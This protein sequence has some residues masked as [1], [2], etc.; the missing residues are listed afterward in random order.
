MDVSEILDFFEEAIYTKLDLGDLALTEIPHKTFEFT[1]LTNLNLSQ[2]SLT[3]IPVEIVHLTKLTN[4]NLSHN[5]LTSLPWEMSKMA[6]LT[7]LDVKRNNLSDLPREF[8]NLM[9]LE[10]LNL[11]GNK[12]TSIPGCIAHLSKLVRLD[13]A[14]NEIADI[15]V[16]LPSRIISLDLGA[17]KLRSF[18]VPKNVLILDLSSN[19]LETIDTNGNESLGILKIDDN[20][21]KSLPE[22]GFVETVTLTG[23]VDLLY[24]NAYCGPGETMS[25][26]KQC[27]LCIVQS[28][29]CELQFYLE[30]EALPY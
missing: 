3:R 9:A 20:K 8:S 10:V 12:F 29:L 7:V 28:Y 16:E 27:K 14:K 2:N 4:L 5:H 23:N 24:A 21:F 18:K 17:N 30:H 19:E 22:L 1:Q 25:H 11:E 6:N 26:C 15:T 13:M